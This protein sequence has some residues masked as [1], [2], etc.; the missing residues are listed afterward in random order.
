MPLRT[1]K[2]GRGASRTTLP[3]RAWER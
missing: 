3:R 2:P 1:C